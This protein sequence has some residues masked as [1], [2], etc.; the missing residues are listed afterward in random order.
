MIGAFR[1]FRLKKASSLTKLANQLHQ[2]I[3]Q[4]D[5]SDTNPCCFLYLLLPVITLPSLRV[6]E[7]DPLSQVAD[8]EIVCNRDE[9]ILSDF[10]QMGSAEF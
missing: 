6:C 5:I 10:L 1:H 2:T 7:S 9:N 3:D 8:G 4:V